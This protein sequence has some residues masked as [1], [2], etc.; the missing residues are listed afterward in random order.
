MMGHI[1]TMDYGL[2][3][4]LMGIDEWMAL[5]LLFAPCKWIG[6]IECCGGQSKTGHSIPMECYNTPK[7][8]ASQQGS[9]SRASVSSMSPE[10]EGD[11][12]PEITSTRKALQEWSGAI[13]CCGGQS[14]TGHSIPMECYNTPKAIASR[15]G[16]PARA[17]DFSFFNCHQRAILCPSF[18]LLPSCF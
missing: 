16:S 7:A 5:L 1:W 18:S 11:S 14:K 9:P 8:I 13:E 6:A 10:T 2:W 12:E 15:Q 17:S 3:R 4:L